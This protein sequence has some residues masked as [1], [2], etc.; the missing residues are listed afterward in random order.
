[1]WGADGG[2]A[3]VEIFGGGVCGSVDGAF[4]DNSYGAM[5]WPSSEGRAISVNMGKA[6]PTGNCD[7]MLDGEMALAHQNAQEQFEVDTASYAHREY[8]VPTAFGDCSWGGYAQVGCN[9]AGFTIGKLARLARNHLARLSRVCCPL[10]QNSS[11]HE[12]MR[13]CP[14]QWTTTAGR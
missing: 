14:S 4:R 6:A 12:L 13:P 1:M 2:S 10:Q 9:R 5:S 3:C 11:F 7:A 8:I